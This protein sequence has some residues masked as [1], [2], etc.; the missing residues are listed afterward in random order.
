MFTREVSGCNQMVCGIQEV[1]L[2]DLVV[3]SGH[4]LDKHKDKLISTHAQILNT[5]T[6]Q[7]FRKDKEVVWSGLSLSKGS[8]S[9]KQELRVMNGEEAGKHYVK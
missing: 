7:L 1:R 4:R 2:N 5:R 3:P 9:Y 6:Q 8:F